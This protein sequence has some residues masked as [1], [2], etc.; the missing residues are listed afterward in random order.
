MLEDRDYMRQPESDDSRWRPRFSWRWS[1]TTGFLAAYLVI[2]LAELVLRKFQPGSQLFHGQLAVVNGALAFIPGWLPLSLEGIWNGYF[3]QLLTYQFLHA[4]WIHLLLNGWVIYMFGR[5]LEAMLGGKKFVALMLSGGVIGG[6]F[7]VLVAL[8]WPQ[9]F[10]THLDGG[11]NLISGETVGASA[12][13]FGLVAAFAAMFPERELTLLIFFVIPV[14]LRAKSLLIISGIIALIGFGL[15]MD[16]V[17]H[18][19]HLG[20]MA[21]GWFFVR[22]IMR[23]DGALLTGQLRVLTPVER[24]SRPPPPEKSTAEIVAEEVDP[25]LDKISAHGIQ[26]LT[27]REKAVLENARKKMSSR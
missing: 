3:W 25:I 12:C 9:Y 10:G 1:W 13:A 26:S 14:H 17:A 18:A 4:G 2:F 15:H 20:G 27:V 6:V 11:N 23:A 21:M 19:A 5:E 7:Q 22:R 24:E 16:N 8:L